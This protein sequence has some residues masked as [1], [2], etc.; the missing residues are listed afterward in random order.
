MQQPSKMQYP[1]GLFKLTLRSR[2]EVWLEYMLDT[3]EEI[4]QIRMKM[5]S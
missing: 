5:Q 2:R 3:L 1:L 4:K